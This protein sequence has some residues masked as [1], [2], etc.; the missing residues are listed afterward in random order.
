V[1]SIERGDAGAGRGRLSKLARWAYEAGKFGAVGAAAWVVD[2][3]FYLLATEGPGRLM[4]AWPVRASILASLVATA[5][6]YFGNR[7]WTFSRRRAKLPAKEVAAF[8]AAN[9]V[10][11]LITGA[12]LYFSRWVLGFHGAA[13]DTLA[14]NI[15]IALGTVFRYLAYKFWV[16]N[17]KTTRTR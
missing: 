9:V 15:G 2:N 13:P 5:F 7:Y 12:C 1:G 16:F 17:A 8:A 14:R 3:G 4:A 6:S 10:G 11:V